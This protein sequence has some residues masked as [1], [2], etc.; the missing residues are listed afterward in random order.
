MRHGSFSATA[1]SRL[2]GISPNEGFPSPVWALF[3]YTINI[4]HFLTL[5]VHS[6]SPSCVHKVCNR[7]VILYVFQLVSGLR[8]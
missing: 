5:E 3:Q 2:P 8:F 1:F 6:S 4:S 7:Y